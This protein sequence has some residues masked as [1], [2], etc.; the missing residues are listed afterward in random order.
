M[1]LDISKLL[2][3]TVTVFNR[4]SAKDSGERADVYIPTVLFPASWSA[5]WERSTDS[6]G[7][8]HRTRSVRIQVPDS[9]AEYLP[10][11]EWVEKAAESD[12]TGVYTLSLGDFAARGEVPVTGRLSRSEVV[13]ALRPYP[14]CEI[15]AVQDCRSGGAASVGGEV[16][17]YAAVVFAQG[18]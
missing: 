12:L 10:Y 13:A 16:G 4:L 6:G 5:T 3:R 7:V 1:E 9:T 15:N 8:V 17:K 11:A 2:D 18:I 14:Y